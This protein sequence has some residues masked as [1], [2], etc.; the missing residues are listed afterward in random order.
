MTLLEYLKQQTQTIGVYP[1]KE[2]DRLQQA[3][4]DVYLGRGVLEDLTTKETFRLW[5]QPS[6]D[7][8]L[9][10]GHEYKY[11]YGASLRDPW[12]YDLL[13]TFNVT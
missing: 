5:Q 6:A 9:V 13:F 11:T 8:Q 10:P 12:Y 4:W 7:V 1:E 2:M 3:L